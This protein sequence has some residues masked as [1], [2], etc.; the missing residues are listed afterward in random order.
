[1]TDFLDALALNA[2]KTVYKG[3]Y[4]TAA[5]VNHS[6]VSLRQAILNCQVNPIITEIKSASPSLGTIRTYVEA[7]KIALT[8]EKN[9][10]VAIS[11]LTEPDFFNGSLKALVYAREAVKIP[12][13][14][15]DIIL[16]PRQLNAAQKMGADAVLLIQAVF[17]RGY[18]EISLDQMISNAHEAGLEVLL[19]AHSKNEF[20]SAL[21]SEADLLGINNR[22]LT[23]LNIDLGTTNKILD[24]TDLKGK[25]IV[26]ES[27]INTPKDLLSLKNC[28]A[29]AFLIGS[30]IMSSENL[31][32]KILEF[33]N[34]K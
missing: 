3:Y 11:V 15:K 13:L 29:S 28:G 33:V 4:E 16:S 17:D 12:I 24:Q 5:P 22:D 21:Q 7:D 8:M 27:G 2:T 31:E 10:A 1:M 20:D 9:G 18:S 14:M 30:A 6:H 23:T 26:S 32:S 25:V 19:E 34:A